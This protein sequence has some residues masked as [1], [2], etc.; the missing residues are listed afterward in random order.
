MCGSNLIIESGG[1]KKSKYVCSGYFNRGTCSNKLYIRKDDL[2]VR[3]LT[4]F[5][6]ELLQPEAV[7]L[8]IEAFGRQ[9]RS[10]L[11]SVSNE[12]GEMRSRKEK[13]E[14][15]IRNYT[16]AIGESGHSKYILEE[17]AVREK[18]ISAITDRLL[19]CSPDS[20]Q[21]QI[22]EMR[23]LV[24][25]GIQNVHRLCNEESPAA[26]QEL[27]SHLSAIRMYPT[28]DGEG[29]YY[30]AEGTWNLLGTDPLAPQ[31]PIVEEG[32]LRMVAG[33]GFEPPTFGL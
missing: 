14:R 5:Q 6:L 32:R 22:D 13:L 11:A 20:I 24:E 7:E 1:G 25:D 19:S 33:G 27:H 15:E 26:K 2:E 17:I 23:R 28:E 16:A 31:V 30:V 9:L 29:W 10:S 18:E 8:A 4:K 21:A 3:L 12:I